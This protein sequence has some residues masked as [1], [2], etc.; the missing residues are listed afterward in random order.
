MKSLLLRTFCVMIA[1]SAF[2]M[3]RSVLLT[4]S[5]TDFYLE[6]LGWDGTQSGN[7]DILSGTGLSGSVSV[8]P[9]I[10]APIDT[11]DLEFQVGINSSAPWTPAPYEL[12]YQLTVEGVTQTLKHQVNVN[13]GWT[14][15][16]HI[17]PTTAYFN[18]AK[19]LVKYTADPVSFIGTDLGSHYGKLSGKLEVVPEP[20]TIA[21]AAAG[22]GVALRRRRAARR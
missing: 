14:D 5:A 22:L 21:L 16:L 1:V 13:I 20:A 11:H 19:G 7:F 9:G 17:L 6:K 4:Y 15:D 18:T 8:T 3:G 2:A 10:P 12:S